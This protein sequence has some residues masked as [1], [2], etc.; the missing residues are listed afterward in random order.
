[1]F[2]SKRPSSEG[3]YQYI[4]K[5]LLQCHGYKY[6]LSN[7]KMYIDLLKHLKIITISN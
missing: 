6:L 5:L 1:M 4:M 2:Q 3:H 7:T